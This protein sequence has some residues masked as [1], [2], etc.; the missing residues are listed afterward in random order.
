MTTVEALRMEIQSLR[1]EV[2]RQREALGRIAD[3]LS[4]GPCER[5][6]CAGCRGEMNE[7]LHIASGM[8]VQEPAPVPS[9]FSAVRAIFAGHSLQ[10]W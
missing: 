4:P 6:T 8:I 1:A 9:R 3:T 10:S 7:A 5:C 2:D